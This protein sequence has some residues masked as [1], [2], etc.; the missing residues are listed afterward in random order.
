M[1]GE[2]GGYGMAATW[3][4]SGGSIAEPRS[5]SSRSHEGSKGWTSTSLDACPTG[6]LQ[7]YGSSSKKQTRGSQPVRLLLF[8]D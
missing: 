8:G 3:Q 2:H 4:Q 5:Q 1:E 6:G 7:E